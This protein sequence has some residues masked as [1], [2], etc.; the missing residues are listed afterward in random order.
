MAWTTL[1]FGK[2]CSG[3]SSHLSPADSRVRGGSK[4]GTVSVSQA[5]PCL[6]E[7]LPPNHNP[8][9]AAT[10]LHSL[11]A[12]AND[13]GR[14]LAILHDAIEAELQVG[15]V[16]LQRPRPLTPA[17]HRAKLACKAC[18]SCMHILIRHMPRPYQDGSCMC[19][20]IEA[21]LPVKTASFTA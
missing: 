18:C 19:S 21:A 1:L 10:A 11:L 5:V 9:Q 4:H 6:V 15:K 12:V 13:G 2:N 16:S 3:G 7:G 14:F 17:K 8:M 20:A